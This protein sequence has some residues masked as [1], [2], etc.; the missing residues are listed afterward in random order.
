MGTKDLKSIHETIKSC[1][2]CSLKKND[3]KPVFSKGNEK[4]KIIL[5]GEAPGAE[6]NKEGLPFVGHS[7]QILNDLLKQVGFDPINDI[8]FTNTV[9]CRPTKNG[10][11]RKPTEK[12]RL[13]CKEYLEA[14]INIVKPKIIIL[15]GKTAAKAFDIKGSMEKIHGDVNRFNKNGIKL[16]PVYHPR[17]S[18]K[19]ELKLADLR[20][21]KNFLSHQEVE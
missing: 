4:A 5:I 3:I 9:K 7:G 20:K 1:K 13:A 6:E 16:I 21:I 2:N 14:E 10:K 15:C 17:A 8:Y 19:K 11:D 18:V 12:E